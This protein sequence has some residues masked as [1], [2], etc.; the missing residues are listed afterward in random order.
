VVDLVPAVG[1][2]LPPFRCT[3]WGASWI[4]TDIPS[5]PSLSVKMGSWSALSRTKRLKLWYSIGI[6]N[7]KKVARPA[8]LK[9]EISGAG[10]AIIIHALRLFGEAWQSLCRVDYLSHLSF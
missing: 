6:Y 4:F 10:R 3:P 9:P 7:F 2:V 1:F 5:T 8:L